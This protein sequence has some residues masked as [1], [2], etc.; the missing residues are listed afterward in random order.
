M[1]KEQRHEVVCEQSEEQAIV[2]ATVVSVALP[3]PAKIDE[4]LSRATYIAKRLIE[5]A[6]NSDMVWRPRESRDPNDRRLTADGWRMLAAWCGVTV[7]TEIIERVY[8]E[9]GELI[10]AIAKATLYRNG[11]K[12]G[13]AVGCCE[14]GEKLQRRGNEGEYGRWSNAMDDTIESVAQTRAATEACKQNFG[15]IV[16]LAGFRVT[17]PVEQT[18]PQQQQSELTQRDWARFWMKVRELGF[19]KEE[20]HE[21]YSV[22]SMKELAKTPADLDR[23]LSELKELSQ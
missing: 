12:I 20:L 4:A 3:E 16:R 9:N 21:L 18:P 2:P 13:G 5:I 14:R 10:R 1:Q 15:F 22:S 19:T 8:D 23:I 11:E 7:E 17:E 6:E